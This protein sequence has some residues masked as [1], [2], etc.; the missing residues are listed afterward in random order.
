MHNNL[1]Y[2][3]AW[4]SFQKLI[5]DIK[6]LNH[7]NN[8]FER[9]VLDWFERFISSR[10]ESK[11]KKWFH[12]HLN[13]IIFGGSHRWIKTHSTASLNYSLTLL[14]KCWKV[15]ENV[16]KMRYHQWFN[17]K[18]TRKSENMVLHTHYHYIHLFVSF[19]YGYECWTQRI[20]WTNQK[21]FTKCSRGKVRTR[22]SV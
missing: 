6:H 8:H 18:C 9:F 4:K 20:N 15:T 10:S 17:D 21:R 14:M 13:A 11:A 19:G 7:C 12:I 3:C 1:T 5:F 22:Y 16:E 2:K